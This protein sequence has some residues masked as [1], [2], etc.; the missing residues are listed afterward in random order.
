MRL[1]KPLQHICSVT[2]TLHR[3]NLLCAPFLASS[4]SFTAPSNLLSSFPPF[5]AHVRLGQAQAASS[6]IHDA[7]VQPQLPPQLFGSLATA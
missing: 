2:C 4:S 1:V 7:T 3:L 6:D 5:G